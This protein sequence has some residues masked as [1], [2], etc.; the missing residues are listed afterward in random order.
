MCFH[1]IDYWYYC[2]RVRELQDPTI[3]E[4]QKARRDAIAL[5]ALARAPV[6]LAGSPNDITKEQ[7][8]AYILPV[9]RCE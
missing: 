4:A 5:L 1:I 7:V 6:T 3:Y 8:E 9:R 2:L